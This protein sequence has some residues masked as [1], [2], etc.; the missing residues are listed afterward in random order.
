LARP[1]LRIEVTG[2]DRKEL[3]D[4][5]SGGI[6][7]VRLVLRVLSLLQLAKGVSAPQVAQVV[8]PDAADDS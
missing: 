6:Q 4:L 3:R 1:G 7:Q 8:P 2:K 5:L